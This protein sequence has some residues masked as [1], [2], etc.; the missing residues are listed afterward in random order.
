M[1]FFD[2]RIQQNRN[3]RICE[4]IREVLHK[5]FIAARQAKGTLGLDFFV[6]L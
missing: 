2:Y 3:A 5:D 1:N 6:R 4:C